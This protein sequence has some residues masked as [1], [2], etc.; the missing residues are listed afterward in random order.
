M[1]IHRADINLDVKLAEFDVWVTPSIVEIK[2][3]KR[4]KDEMANIL[5]ALDVLGS[6][7]RT[8][9]ENF[10]F[11][12][13]QRLFTHLDQIAHQKAVE[14]KNLGVMPHDASA[15]ILESV[16]SLI[17]LVTGKSDNNHKCQ[18]PIFLRNDLGWQGL[19]KVR[20]NRSGIR[21]ENEAIPRTLDSKSFLNRAAALLAA[22]RLAD[23]VHFSDNLGLREASFTLV[24]NF[25][26]SLIPDYESRAQL[27]AFISHYDQCKASKSDPTLILA[28]LALFQVRGSVAATGGHEPEEILRK[29]MSEWGMRASVDF[30][31]TDVI[32]D[33]KLQTLSPTYENENLNQAVTFV[34]TRAYDFIIPFKTHGWIPRLFIQSQFYAGDSGSVS[35][36]NVDQTRATRIATSNFIKE[37]WPG[38]PAP[39]YV[40]YLDGAGYC[41]SLNGDLKRLLSFEDTADFFQI[42]SAP[43]RLRRL[44]Q[45]IGFLTPLEVCHA[46][47]S[48]SGV[49]ANMALQLKREGY[50]ES[51][52]C[53]GIAH[54]IE[55]GA[56]HSAG[57]QLVI[58]ESFLEPA[59]RYYV[60][61]HIAKHGKPLGSA[62][63]CKGCALI[64]G[65][66]P[67]FGIGL[68]QL[69]SSLS[70]VT[71]G[72]SAI[73]FGELLET[74]SKNGEIILR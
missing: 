70:L 12:L 37:N 1:K 31:T 16:A 62:V 64:P 63:H 33:S 58:S 66:G 29:K 59:Q 13:T 71:N 55:V 24:Y 22:A 72:P 61:D 15:S 45:E 7:S 10:A 50:G 3:T 47:I 11:E 35:H 40:E 5:Q 23:P 46:A 67:Y 20:L 74:L 60:L 27:A 6:D 73:E 39:L 56:I 44:I 51:E 34:K 18:L 2:S 32:V 43:V 38:A 52:I 19:P 53:R 9:D 17:F 21:L 41:A 54:A 57:D 69:V 4:F 28:P 36:K 48:C 14:A 25:I 26:A 65:F 8:N 30:N 49:S 68:G 42:R